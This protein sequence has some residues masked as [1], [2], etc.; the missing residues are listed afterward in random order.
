[1]RQVGGSA[2]HELLNVCLRLFGALLSDK[3]NT[4]KTQYLYIGYHSFCL[5]GM[6]ITIL[7]CDTQLFEDPDTSPHLSDLNKL[8]FMFVLFVF[9]DTLLEHSFEIRINTKLNVSR[10][11]IICIVL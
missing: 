4:C 11:I 9:S 3:S 10:I 2:Q 5:C 1:M 7:N 8:K 6:M